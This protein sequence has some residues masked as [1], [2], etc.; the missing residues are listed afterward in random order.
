MAGCFKKME[1]EPQRKI[2]SS[3]WLTLI[4]ILMWRHD[5]IKSL[6]WRHDRSLEVEARPSKGFRERSSQEGDQLQ[7]TKVGSVVPSQGSKEASW[8]CKSW[9]QARSLEAKERMSPELIVHRSYSVFVL[10]PCNSLF[11]FEIIGLAIFTL[12]LHFNEAYFCDT[13]HIT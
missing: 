4:L 9:R 1:L 10:S 6:K 12:T 3:T 8:L 7:T 11:F 2:S 5:H 13:R